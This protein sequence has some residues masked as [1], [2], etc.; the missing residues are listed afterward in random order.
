MAPEELAELESAATRL[1]QEGLA[2]RADIVRA[3][4]RKLR[5]LSRPLHAEALDDGLEGADAG[6]GPGDAP[7][8]PGATTRRQ[9]REQCLQ[10]ESRREAESQSSCSPSCFQ[11]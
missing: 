1:N 5:A 2:E 9:H 10:A 7:G 11:A 3:L 4:A 8:S 6:R